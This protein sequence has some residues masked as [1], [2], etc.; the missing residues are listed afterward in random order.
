MP[1]A[2]E[3][4]TRFVDGLAP[5]GEPIPFG[6]NDLERREGEGVDGRDAAVDLG[7]RPAFGD[8]GFGLCAISANSAEI[9]FNPSYWR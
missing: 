1:V 8:V 2:V 9:P 3:K 5:V 7:H 4:V 6:A